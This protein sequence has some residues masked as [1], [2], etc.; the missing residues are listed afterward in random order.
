[1]R[2]RRHA[3]WP[4]TIALSARLAYQ[5]ALPPD[6]GWQSSPKRHAA[7]PRA[8][9]IC[10]WTRF[11]DLTPP[12]QASLGRR[13]R[14]P[15]PR[16]PSPLPAL[17]QRP[18]GPS[19]RTPPSQK[20]ITGRYG[21]PHLDRQLPP[22]VALFSFPARGRQRHRALRS[23]KKS[24][25]S[26]PTRQNPRLART[27]PS[28]S[29]RRTPLPQR[30]ASSNRLFASAPRREKPYLFSILR[31]GQVVKTAAFANPKSVEP[32]VAEGKT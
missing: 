3:C 18:G 25:C 4:T 14:T 10:V 27:C 16:I 26:H 5:H 12:N 30:S 11:W 32:G 6:R 19:G 23:P 22:P 31:P 8:A 13:I 2:Q 24:L 29:S 1:M 20:P 7:I 28:P 17:R 9:G 15:A 21:S